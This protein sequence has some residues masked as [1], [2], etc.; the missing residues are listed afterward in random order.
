[1]TTICR[2]EAI[3]ASRVAAAAG[4]QQGAVAG[5][6]GDV[7]VLRRAHTSPKLKRMKH[8]LKVTQYEAVGILESLWHMTA[9]QAPR[10]DIG[11][12]SNEDIAAQLEWAGDEKVLI[13]AL[14]ACGWL[15]RDPEHRLLVHDWS[16]H[17]DQNVRRSPQV[18]RHGFAGPHQP[19]TSD[20]PLKH[21]REPEKEARNPHSASE[22]SATPATR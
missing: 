8:R 21:Q 11:K 4:L 22:P 5:K 15:D 6:E 19:F 3:H 16:V 13:D 9:T 10:G 1:M 18:K 7:A 20:S 17:A 12:W 2:S 14:V